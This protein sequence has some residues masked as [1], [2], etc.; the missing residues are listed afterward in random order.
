LDRLLRSVLV[1]DSIEQNV[2]MTAALVVLARR[3]FERI[4]V[5]IERDAIVARM[6]DRVLA[7]GVRDWEACGVQAVVAQRWVVRAAA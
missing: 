6:I 7:A 3:V 4:A 1:C 5:R 2:G